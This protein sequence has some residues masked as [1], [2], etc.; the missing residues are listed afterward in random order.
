MT[1]AA[2]VLPHDPHQTCPHQT[3]SSKADER[4]RART[5]GG[6]GTASRGHGRLNLGICHRNMRQYRSQCRASRS[7]KDFGFGSQRDHVEGFS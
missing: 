4:Q 3:C 6:G 1:A 7:Q 5:H 2:A